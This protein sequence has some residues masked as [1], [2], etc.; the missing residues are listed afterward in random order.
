MHIQHKECGSTWERTISAQYAFCSRLVHDTL[1]YDA[2]T[3][4]DLHLED[5]RWLSLS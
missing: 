1:Q 5:R 3:S 4:R 2:G